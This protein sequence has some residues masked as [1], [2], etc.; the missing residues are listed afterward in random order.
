LSAAL[1]AQAIAGIHAR[2]SGYTGPTTAGHATADVVRVAVEQG[3]VHG[4][5]VALVFAFVVVG[6]G[7]FVSLLIPNTAPIPASKRHHGADG[8]EPLEP[9][10]PDP[11]LL[12]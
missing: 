1:K 12:H 7:T 11:A 8:F 5:R 2:G 10:D 9:L 6:I 4:T 3:V